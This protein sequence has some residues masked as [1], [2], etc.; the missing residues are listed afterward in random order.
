MKA[1]EAIQMFKTEMTQRGQSETTW[2]TDYQKILRR[3]D[4]EGEIDAEVLHDIVVA[5]KPNTKTRRRACMVIGALANYLEID[6]DPK[7][8]QGKYSA[9]RPKPRNISSD[10]QIVQYWQS[11][12]NPA[13]RW[14]FG[15]M[16]AYGLRNHE[17]VHLDME[18]LKESPVLWVL[19]GKTG[20]RRVR[21]LHPEWYEQLQLNKPR[22]PNIN[23]E[24]PNDK[25]GHSITRYFADLK[26]PPFFNLYSLRHAY[27]I[28][29]LR[30]RLQTK[31]TA[32]MM[33][34]SAIVHEEIYRLW[35]DEFVIDEAYTAATQRGDRP[36]PPTLLPT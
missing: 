27:A 20:A 17:V 1:K 4:P 13:Y 32:K 11:L 25:I 10:E 23:L 22:L 19:A 31:I 18:M 14:V 28:R 12:A 6:Y 33:G 2:R 21:P 5:T 26:N 24:R 15:M 9:R 8:Y 3:L 16:A 34:H 30:Y 29:A 7:P 36:Q 35:I